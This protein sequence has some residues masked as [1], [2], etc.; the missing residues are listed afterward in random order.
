MLKTLN[1]ALGLLTHFSVRQPSWGVRELAKHA[2][3]HH[4]VVHRVLATFAANGFLVQDAAGRYGLGLRWLELGQATR[5][6][7]SPSEVVQ[8]ALEALAAQSGETVF[9]SWRE[10]FEG[11]CTDIAQSPHQLRFSIEVGQRFPLF[12]GA[13]AKAILAFQDEALRLQVYRAGGLQD[14]AVD[15]LEAQLTR[16]RADGW[17]H[18][19]EEAAAAVAGVAVPL[20]SRDRR[21]V[22]G[23]LGIAGPL[24]RLDIQAVPRLLDAMRRAKGPI[25]EVAGFI[26]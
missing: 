5:K 2:G 12:A 17:A 9:L 16:I 21:A 3:I 13:H 26:R 7:F 10:G 11:L 24:Q 20:W 19:R 23:S 8:P 1:G 14:A 4:A 6:A 18:T 15:A 22:V 25:E